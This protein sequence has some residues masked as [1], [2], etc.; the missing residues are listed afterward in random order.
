M[1]KFTTYREA[2]RANGGQELEKNTME[3][4]KARVQE[5]M[6]AAAEQDE[7]SDDQDKDSGDEG[8]E[9]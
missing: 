4:R 8:D 3:G 7:G 1:T 2:F 5:R 9:E 6:K